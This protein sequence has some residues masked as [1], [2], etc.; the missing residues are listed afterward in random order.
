ME[1][2]ELLSCKDSDYLYLN[3]EDYFSIAMVDAKYKFITIGVGLFGK[4][5]DSEI[6]LKTDS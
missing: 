5:G 2:S 3:Y 6:F 4:V 1:L